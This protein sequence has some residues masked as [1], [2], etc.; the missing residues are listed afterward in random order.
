AWPARDEQFSYPH[1]APTR[2]TIRRAAPDSPTPPPP[3]PLVRP[4]PMAPGARLSASPRWRTLH[5]HCSE[6]DVAGPNN[7]RRLVSLDVLS[8][9]YPARGPHFARPDA[10]F[11]SPADR[12]GADIA[13]RLGDDNPPLG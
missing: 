3:S 11:R 5:C 8:H 9:L 10:D 4:R 12:V 2:C 7:K 6:R 1:E 13:R